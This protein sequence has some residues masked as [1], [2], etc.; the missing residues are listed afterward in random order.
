MA[1]MLLTA[2]ADSSRNGIMMVITSQE[3]DEI[4]INVIPPVIPVSIDIDGIKA[5]NAK[6]KASKRKK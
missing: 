2:V 6:K 4:P 5:Y 1:F 3:F